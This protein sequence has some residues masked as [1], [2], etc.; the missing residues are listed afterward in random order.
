MEPLI[1]GFVQEVQGTTAILLLGLDHIQCRLEVFESV[2]G[3]SGDVVVLEEARS[4]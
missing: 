1:E 2:K 4:S 3:L